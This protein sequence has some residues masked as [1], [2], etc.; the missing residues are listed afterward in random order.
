ML[1]ATLS[2]SA[3]ASAQTFFSMDY[4]AAADPNA[5]WNA[6][7]VTS[8]PFNRQRIAGGGPSGQDAYDL[9]Q[10]RDTSFRPEFYGGQFRWGWS[11]NIEPSDPPQGARRYY[12][13]RMRFS[14]DTNFRAVDWGNGSSPSALVNKV[15]LVGDGGRTDRCRV[16]LEYTADPDA[17]NVRRMR[18]QIDGGEDP[19]L[20]GPW[21]IGQW[22]NIQIEVD[23]SSTPSSPDGGYKLWINNNDYG[24]PTAQTTGITLLTSNWKFVRLGAFVSHGLASGGVHA[25]RHTDFQA[26]TTFDPNW[27]SGQRAAPRPPSGIT[28]E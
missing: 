25:F 5:A 8:G 22:L 18:L 15:F 24:S 9:I 7:S 2:A 23:S 20:S 12:R 26:S 14:P 28:V 27:N 1:M 10:Y 4:S 19:A 17:G 13:W 21:P 16:I 3:P 6:E 11:G